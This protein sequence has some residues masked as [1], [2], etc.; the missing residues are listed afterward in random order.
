MIDII[1]SGVFNNAFLAGFLAAIACG[2]IGTYVVVNRLVFISGGITHTAYGGIGFAV[3]AGISPLLGAVIFS[4]AAA[5]VIA[6]FSFGRSHRTD[7]FIGALW[8]FGMALGIIL[9]DLTPGYNVDL[10]SYLFGSILTV[11]ASDI[12]IM[13]LVDI[14]L[15]VMIAF[16]YKDLLLMS[17]DAEFAETAGVNTKLLYTLLLVLT[18][19]SVVLIIRVVGIILVIALLTIPPYI[20][21]KRSGSLFGMM[22]ISII[23]NLLFIFSGMMLAFRFNLTTGAAIIMTASAVFILNFIA[24]KLRPVS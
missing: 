9:M 22:V 20:A 23:L 17:Y 2:I 21:E 6:I 16:L 10:M 19:V 13:I 7:T 15:I 18:A 12:Y 4:V 14:V 11:P 8:A 1:T 24:L 5:L 3:F